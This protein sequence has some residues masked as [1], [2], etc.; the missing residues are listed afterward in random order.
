M[1]TG[2]K[3]HHKKPHGSQPVANQSPDSATKSPQVSVPTSTQP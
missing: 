1:P 2:T 3:K